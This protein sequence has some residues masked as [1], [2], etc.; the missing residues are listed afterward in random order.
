MRFVSFLQIYIVNYDEKGR[1][2]SMQGSD[3]QSMQ[4]FTWRISREENTSENEC[5]QIYNK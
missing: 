1:T 5:R 3:I 4:D 2:T